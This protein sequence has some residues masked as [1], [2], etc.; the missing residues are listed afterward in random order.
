[1]PL[2]RLSITAGKNE[3]WIDTILYVI[4]DTGAQLD[5]R[6]IEF[7]MEIRRRAEDNEV[8]LSAATANKSIFIGA[9]PNFGYLVIYVARRV[10][11]YLFAGQYVGDIRARDAR[12]ERVCLE[13]DLTI[14]EGVT[15]GSVF[16]QNGGGRGILVGGSRRT[17]VLVG[18]PVP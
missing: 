12:F 4:E 8:I 13:I 5:L 16:V 15:K 9:A 6:G 2:A 18:A 3:D 14:I 1:L 10:M 17:E 11:Q 7:E